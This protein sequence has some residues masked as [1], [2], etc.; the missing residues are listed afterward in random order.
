MNLVQI[1][2]DGALCVWKVHNLQLLQRFSDF[3]TKLVA[4]AAEDQEKG[5]YQNK[6]HDLIL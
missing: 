6:T 4:Y 2:D 1:I 3:G 5:K